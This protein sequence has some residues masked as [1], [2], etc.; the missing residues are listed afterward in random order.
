MARSGRLPPGPPRRRT[1]GAR[2]R[3][4]SWRYDPYAP[5]SEFVKYF[6]SGRSHA[7]EAVR[8]PGQT[9]ARLWSRLEPTASG[10]W[11]PSV[12]AQPGWEA[13]EPAPPRDEELE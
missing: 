6:T 11:T 8:S 5:P 9:E 12:A 10:R 1:G 3:S 4:R 7:N 2:P 13:I